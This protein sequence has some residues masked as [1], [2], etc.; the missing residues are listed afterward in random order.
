MRSE[1]F[2]MKLPITSELREEDVYHAGMVPCLSIGGHGVQDRKSVTD[3][4][5]IYRKS[6]SRPTKLSQEAMILVAMDQER[7]E[8]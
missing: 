6:S 4:T 8:L 2:W 1:D 5:A 7:N 3:Q